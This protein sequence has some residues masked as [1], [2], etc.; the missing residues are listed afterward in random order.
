[1]SKPPPMGCRDHGGREEG[2]TEP[3]KGK[4]AR[5]RGVVGQ[6]ARTPEVQDL[7][8]VYAGGVEGRVTL[9]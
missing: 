4:K 1:M 7:E 6:E 8:G 9:V 2:P 3:R 5:K